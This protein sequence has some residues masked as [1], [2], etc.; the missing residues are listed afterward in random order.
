MRSNRDSFHRDLL[1]ETYLY[2]LILTQ[3]LVLNFRLLNTIYIRFFSYL[4]PPNW[5]KE[6][7]DIE[8]IE[9]QKVSSQCL[10][11]GSPSP[12]IMWRKFSKFMNI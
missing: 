10:A 9:G 11:T 6:P 5:L 7:E 1:K 2:I 8:A 3:I 4:A 12:A